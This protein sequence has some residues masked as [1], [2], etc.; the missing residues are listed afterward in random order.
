MVN[1]IINAIAQR[2]NE[3]YPN[4]KCYTDDI[5]QKFTLPAFVIFT[6]DQD[7]SKRLNSKYKSRIGF[8]L[9]YFSDKAK[10][11]IKS[12]CLAVQENLLRN[13]DVLKTFKVV[14][15]NA[16]ITDNV[17][18]VTFDINYSEMKIEDQILMQTQTTNTYS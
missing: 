16:R 8:D 17:L 13:F 2:L 10:Q 5:P 15:K 9:A 6:I 4:Y 14:N 18:H 3:L 1:E 11:E 7:Y 12:D